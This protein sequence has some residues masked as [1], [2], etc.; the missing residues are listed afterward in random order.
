MQALT[1][2]LTL[3]EKG[4]KFM[5]RQKYKDAVY[6][7]Q[8]A[9]ESLSKVPQELLMTV[10]NYGLLALDIVWSLY[11]DQNIAELSNAGKW[12][13]IAELGL[14]RAHGKN[15]S[16]L[17]AVRAA[18]GKHSGDFVPEVSL[19]VRLNILRAY[20]AFYQIDRNG[21]HEYL[22][23]AEMDL[24]KLQISDMDLAMLQSMGYGHKES[25]RALRFCGG[26]MDSAIGH[27]I[28]KRE[29]AQRRREEER[30]AHRKRALQRKYGLTQNGKFV[31]LKLLEQLRSMGVE[32][33]I[34]IEALRQTDNAGE[35][36]LDL[37]T[38]AD[39]K[40]ILAQTLFARYFNDSRLHLIESVLG[41]LGADN[42]SEARVRS[43]LFLTYNNVD[44]AIDMLST[45]HD[46]PQN[47][48]DLDRIEVRFVPYVQRRQEKLRREQ[49][50]KQR[51]AEESRKQAELEAAQTEQPQQ[52]EADEDGQDVAMAEQDDD[53]DAVDDADVGSGAEAKESMEVDDEAKEE[54]ESGSGGVVQPVKIEA[55]AMPNPN[56]GDVNEEPKADI[57]ERLVDQFKP[58][59]HKRPNEDDQKIE[60][61][62][63]DDL[64]NDEESYLDID[65]SKE[66][67]ALTNLGAMLNSMGGQTHLSLSGANAKQ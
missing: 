48:V 40:E 35:D 66:Q 62:I 22:M 44:E 38:N 63:L 67:N 25:R 52:P 20:Q 37:V 13:Q 45:Q 17:K 26:D 36:T 53:G 39:R 21:A 54:P 64:D 42:V 31:D 10:D 12:L 32:K 57:T 50:R 59:Q 47:V 5:A 60:E 23:K 4:K 18:S 7:L 43:A 55:K 3:H 1:V 58:I 9:F 56:L 8:L 28:Q 51:E 30:E 16:R 34:A 41:V 33:E 61:H 15:M 2:G 11:L 65:L 19:Y 46:N 6:I 27:I 24:R 49:L 14:E 29:D